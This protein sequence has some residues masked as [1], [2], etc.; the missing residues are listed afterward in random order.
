MP[1]L[2]SSSLC[3]VL[4]PHTMPDKVK[5]N[6]CISTVDAVRTCFLSFFKMRGEAALGS[7]ALAWVRVRGWGWVDALSQFNLK[8]KYKNTKTGLKNLRTK[9]Y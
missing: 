3:D 9:I 8:K 4:N 2:G 1:H 7:E 6:T 5:K